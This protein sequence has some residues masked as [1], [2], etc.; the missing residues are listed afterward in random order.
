MPTPSDDHLG[1]PVNVIAA[2]TESAR[3]GCPPEDRREQHNISSEEHVEAA[4][5]SPAGANGRSEGEHDIT[6]PVQVL[7]P[8][9]ETPVS[10]AP[11]EVER[12][13]SPKAER[14]EDA[15]TAVEP[16]SPTI[17]LLPPPSDA[18]YK[19]AQLAH[20]MSNAAISSAE[21]DDIPPAP[22]YLHYP[23]LDY[24]RCIAP[25]ST[26]SFLRP[27]SKF[28]GT[29]QSDHQ[30]YDVQVELKD[31]DL[32]ESTLCGYLRIQGERAPQPS[33]VVAPEC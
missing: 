11:G 5:H 22:L 12:R 29:Q 4:S 30:V 32:A 28:R 27:G 6:E 16:S 24:N 25:N 14:A 33:C 21:P 8:V 7:T 18:D 19:A 2:D 13:S 9:S 3:H 15:S 10:E 1:S 31:V 17:G 20:S 26:T 23:E